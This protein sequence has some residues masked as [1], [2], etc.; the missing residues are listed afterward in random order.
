[1][2]DRH[3]NDESNDDDHEPNSDNQHDNEWNDDDHENDA[4][5]IR[6]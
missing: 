6:S 1:M 4:G 2:N 5:W 3:H